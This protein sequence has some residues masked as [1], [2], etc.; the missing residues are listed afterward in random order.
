[1]DHHLDLGAPPAMPVRDPSHSGMIAAQRLSAR[2]AEAAAGLEE[3]DA[4][5]LPLMMCLARL[6]A[7][8][9]VQEVL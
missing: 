9:H 8:Q 1:M 3:G 6:A 5:L 2:E 7:R 4:A